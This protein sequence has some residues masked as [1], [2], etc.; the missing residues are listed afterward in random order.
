[1]F[2]PAAKGSTY[3]CY[4]G[5]LT[6]FQNP[7]TSTFRIFVKFPPLS[8]LLWPFF[9]RGGD[10]MFRPN[11]LFMECSVLWLRSLCKNWSERF[12][13]ASG[14]NYGRPLLTEF[15]L[16]LSPV[17]TFITEWFVLHF[18]K[19]QQYKDSNKKII[20]EAPLKKWF[21]VDKRENR[22]L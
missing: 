14:A 1:M 20:S 3:F 22:L 21:W 10:M 4:L 18:W 9:V 5:N 11:F 6:K 7:M 15:F 17:V 8:A 16:F 13:C 19:W 2:V 12:V